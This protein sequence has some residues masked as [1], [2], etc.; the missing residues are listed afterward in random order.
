MGFD[1]VYLPPVHPI[2]RAFR[3]G[4]DNTEAAGPDDPGS[5]WAIGAATGGHAAVHPDARARSTT[6]ARWPRPRRPTGSSWR[7][8]SPS[9]ARR[10]TRGSR[11]TRA[12]SGTGPTARSSTRRTRPKKYQDIYPLD[13]V[14]DGLGGAVG[15]VPRPRPLLGVAGRQ[16]VPRRQPPHQAVRVLG[17]ADR[18]GP[19]APPRDIFLSEAFTRPAIMHRLAEV[20]FTHVV[21]VLPVAGQRRRAARVLHR[22]VDA[23]VGR[24]V[25]PVGWP[26]TPDILPWHLMDAPREVFAARAAPGR[27]ALALVRDLRPGLRARREPAGRRTARRSSPAPR[28]TRSGP[29]TVRRPTRCGGCSPTSTASAPSTG[30]STRCARCASTASTTT[31]SSASRRR[32]TPARRSIPMPAATPPSSSSPTSRADRC[33]PGRS[34]STSGR[35]ASTPTRPFQ[36]HDLLTDLTFTWAGRATTSSSHPD[37]QP[38]H[39]SVAVIAPGTVAHR[40]PGRHRRW[41]RTGG[42][43]GARRVTCAHPTPTDHDDVATRTPMPDRHPTDDPLWFKDAVIYELHVRAFGDSN[44][45]GIGDFDGL[46]ARLDYLQQLGVTAL[47][48]LPFYPSPLR[49][50]GYDI[51]DYSGINPVYGNLRDVQAVPERGPPPRPAGHHRAGA[52]PHQRSAPVVPA[53]PPARQPGSRVARLLR[54]ERHARSATPRSGSSSRTTRPRTGRWDPVAGAYYWHRFFSHQ[55]DLNYD[56]PEVREVMLAVVDK[57]LE[58]GVDGVRLDAVPYLFEREG[59]NCENLPET[60]EYLKDLRAHIDTNYPGRMLLA[61]ANQWPE[62]VA[63]PTSATRRR[64]A[65]RRVPHG[66]PLPAHAP[67]VHGPAHGGPLPGHRHPPARRRPSPELPVG[68]LPAQPRRADPR[69]GHR[70]GARLHVPLLRRRPADAGQRGHPPPPG[71]AA[72]ERPP[73]DRADERPAVLAA[74]HARHLLRRR[75]RHGRQRLP[76]R[77]RQRAH[78]DAVEPRPQRR[79]LATPTPSSSTCR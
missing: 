20:G 2:G 68:D 49:D 73:Q 21:L 77:P 40:A 38:G 33:R 69:D 35:S 65:W 45:D 14:C 62:D 15:G 32:A 10:T 26:T 55:P 42:S 19:R 12:G 46:T 61:E 71:P 9:S 67:A 3:K 51:A 18:R 13:F 52:Q 53:S 5:P 66:V 58:M 1:I 59:T 79:L 16:R 25:P 60:H 57:W 72:A 4:P 44:G 70:R 64:Q 23:A 28:S 74:G 27:H 76:R 36:V 29:G 63:W 24:S 37:V 11:S 43:P 56:N 30:R 50:D 7:S 39:V 22:A 75:A 31:A 78:A 41:D 48:L 47:W 34:T 6:S 8:T 17:V 54:V